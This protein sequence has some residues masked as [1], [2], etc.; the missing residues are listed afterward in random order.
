MND[1]VVSSGAI[2]VIGT[3]LAALAGV[4]TVLFKLLMIAKDS[5]IADLERERDAY[6]SMANDAM[7]SAEKAVNQWRVSRGE[8][9]LVSIPSVVAEHHSPTTKIQQDVADLQTLRARAA[10]IARELGRI[11]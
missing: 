10:V 2:I 7:V 9:P 8:V 1:F 3:L 4:V 6:R 5:R 11:K